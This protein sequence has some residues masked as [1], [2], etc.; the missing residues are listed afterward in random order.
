[1]GRKQ[2]EK[3]YFGN[4]SLVLNDAPQVDDVMNVLVLAANQEWGRGVRGEESG[5]LSWQRHPLTIYELRE[6]E[7]EQRQEEE[8][9]FPSLVFVLR[10]RE[11]H[12][13]SSP[14]F[15]QHGQI[16]ANC[17]HF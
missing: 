7:Q 2:F 6:C 11:A 12:R 13:P 8:K 9:R 10:G 14:S 4:K 5:T 3:K 15:V 17:V 16:G 1:M